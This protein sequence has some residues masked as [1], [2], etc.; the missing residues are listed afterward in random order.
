MH[1]STASN[2]V[3]EIELASMMESMHMSKLNCEFIDIVSAQAEQT[4][5]MASKKD[6][7]KALFS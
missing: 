1:L 3:V 5:I 4:T 2:T 6:K 7:L